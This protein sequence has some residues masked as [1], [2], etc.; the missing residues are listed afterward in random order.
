MRESGRIVVTARCVS[1]G[2]TIVGYPGKPPGCPHCGYLPPGATAGRSS[3]PLPPPGGAPTPVA[4][5]EGAYPAA[6]RATPRRNVKP[7]LWASG[8]IL[9]AVALAGI[10]FAAW[11]AAD[12]GGAVGEP[13]MRGAVQGFLD[14]VH[15]GSNE[16]WGVFGNITRTDESSPCTGRDVTSVTRI[17]MLQDPAASALD[18]EEL[19]S[20]AG[21]GCASLTAFKQKGGVVNVATGAFTPSAKGLERV[22]WLYGRDEDPSTY[23]RFSLDRYRDL[24]IDIGSGGL[25]D[26]NMTVDSKSAERHRGQAATA[27]RGHN[28][29]G[30]FHV[31]VYDSPARLAYSQFSS[32]SVNAT[33]ELVY[34]DEVRITVSTE[35]PRG[36]FVLKEERTG[37]HVGAGEAFVGVVT[38]NQTQ[39]VKLVEVEMRAVRYQSFRDQNDPA[40]G[41]VVAS[42]R[43]D[44]GT[45][46]VNNVSFEYEDLDGDGLVSTGDR[47]RYDASAAKYPLDFFGQTENATPELAFFDLWANAYEGQLLPAPD[48][49]LGLFAVAAVVALLGLRGRRT[50]TNSS[51]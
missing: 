2:S 23:F 21:G 28:A 49:A 40:K 41:T 7:F 27:F 29:T 31:I 33:Y 46:R 34:G 11:K 39:E 51:P 45:K 30:T 20:E 22:Q 3:P 6:S 32:P 26:P 15:H 18:F 44:G 42:M 12:G 1:C 38:P 5:A 16:T 25:P 50:G 43:L 14:A 47:Y 10:G 19:S 8:A 48:L 4:A 35:L 24:D 36:S 17:H 13:A 9:V 37:V